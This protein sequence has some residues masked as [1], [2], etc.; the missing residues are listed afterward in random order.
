MRTPKNR[1]GAV[2][3]DSGGRVFPG[4]SCREAIQ[5]TK[6]HR[7]F[8]NEAAYDF[9]EHRT[10]RSLRRNAKSNARGFAPS[11]K[12]VLVRTKETQVLV[13]TRIIYL[14]LVK[15][16]KRKTEALRHPS[17]SSHQWAAGMAV[18]AGDARQ[19]QPVHGDG[20][21]G[22]TLR[23]AQRRLGGSTR[24]QRVNR[25]GA[26][27]ADSAGT[28]CRR[29]PCLGRGC[30]GGS[31]RVPP[32]G[33]GRRLGSPSLHPDHDARWALMCFCIGWFRCVCRGRLERDVGR[34]CR[35]RFRVCAVLALSV[36]LCGFVAFFALLRTPR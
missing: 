25:G 15:R 20:L 11:I 17:F 33:R 16:D 21:A 3:F 19:G 31:V 9:D 12:F 14:L 4:G 35:G 24:Q 30:L 36:R 7:R 6:S 32:S 1:N 22:G 28:G 18:R 29:E 8:C 5:K 26:G 10:R 34:L 23:T 13:I 2:Q 27:L